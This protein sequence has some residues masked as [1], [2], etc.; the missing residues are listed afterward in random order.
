MSSP[1]SK[2]PADIRS[3]IRSFLPSWIAFQSLLSDYAE[4]RIPA[5]RVAATKLLMALH[6]SGAFVDFPT[7]L[8]EARVLLN[9]NFIE[10][11]EDLMKAGL[12][13]KFGEKLASIQ[14]PAT[15][16][17]ICSSVRSHAHFRSIPLTE[18]ILHHYLTYPAQARSTYILL[19]HLPHERSHIFSGE[20]EWASEHPELSHR[21][22]MEEILERRRFYTS[23][24]WQQVRTLRLEDQKPLLEP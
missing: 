8:L 4:F 24:F 14:N 13:E 16:E 18:E 23:P 12:N 21:P 19:C 10:I 2:L 7:I 15:L 11:L 3:L 6:Q 17:L 5:E 22:L 20:V 1:L 9:V